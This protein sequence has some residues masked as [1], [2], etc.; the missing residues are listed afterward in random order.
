MGFWIAL[1]ALIVAVLGFFA[2]RTR[3]FML[4]PPHLFHCIPCRVIT[5]CMSALLHFLP[6]S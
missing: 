3:A 4:S 1:L 5:G 6:A 2:G